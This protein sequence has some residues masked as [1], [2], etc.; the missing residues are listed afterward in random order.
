VSCKSCQHWDNRRPDDTFS[1][2]P[3]DFGNCASPKW[4][5]GYDTGKAPL[6]GV[7]VEDDEGWGF[8]TGPDFE[9]CHYEPRS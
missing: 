9:C 3:A 7:A 1:R 8:F 6:D 2:Q 5:A 4:H